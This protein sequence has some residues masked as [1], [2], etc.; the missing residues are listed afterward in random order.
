MSVSIQEIVKK[1][2]NS[3]GL[4]YFERHGP[5]HQ[6]ELIDFWDAD[7]FAVGLKKDQKLVYISS[8]DYRNKKLEEMQYY[9]EFELIDDHT[10]E[11]LGSIK[12]LKDLDPEKLIKEMKDFLN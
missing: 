2:L 10:F 4:N 11:S 8:W 12:E 7:S 5:N 3:F 9:A 6:D 1:I